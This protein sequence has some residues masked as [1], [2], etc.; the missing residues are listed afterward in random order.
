M[1][2]NSIIKGILIN[3]KDRKIEEVEFENSLKGV[4]EKLGC[5][6]VT[7][8]PYPFDEKHEIIVDDESLL[9]PLQ[10]FFT[11]NPEDI[12]ESYCG[13]GLIVS[14]DDEGNWQ[15]HNLN[16]EE[17]LRRLSFLRYYRTSEGVVS[18]ILKENF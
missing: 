10:N 7:T 2:E 17:I 6:C 5:D 14:W 16:P 15:S 12:E 11:F 4:Y 3:V 13:N 8:V 18:V 9:K 1:A